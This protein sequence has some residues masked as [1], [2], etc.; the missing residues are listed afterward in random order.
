MLQA[1][2]AM[3]LWGATASNYGTKQ[4]QRVLV[5][6][7]LLHSF[8]AANGDRQMTVFTGRA[9]ETSFV[10]FSLVLLLVGALLLLMWCC[11]GKPASSDASTQTSSTEICSPTAVHLMPHAGS[12]HRAHLLKDCTYVRRAM[13]APVK[14]LVCTDCTRRHSRSDTDT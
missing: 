13:H 1:F 4:L 5:V 7:S 9:T 8:G 3:A 10:H 11:C 14:H 12:G 6:A 2:V